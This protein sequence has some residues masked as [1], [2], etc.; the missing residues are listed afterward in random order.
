MVF[1]LV[2]RKDTKTVCMRN[3][4]M[5]PVAWHMTGLEN[6]GDDFSVS[7]EGGIVQPKSEFSLHVYFRALK[8]VFTNKK[9]VRIEVL[10]SYSIVFSYASLFYFY[11]GCVGINW[12]D[13][14]QSSTEF[15]HPDSFIDKDQ[16][17][18]G[19]LN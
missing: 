10:M 13:E 11:C 12:F 5:L 7:Q 2:D 3:N 8:P 17:H 16:V 14:G 4:T 18:F 15:F 6:L 19:K 1:T 9:A